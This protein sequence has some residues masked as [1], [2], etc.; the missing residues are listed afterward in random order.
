MLVFISGISTS[1]KT[2]IGKHFVECRKERGENW[3]FKDLDDFYFKEKPKIT[4]SNGQTISNWDCY[5][6]ID[7]DAAKKWLEET[8]FSDAGQN[9]CF[10]GFA[11]STARLGFQ[12]VLHFH[13]S[14][15][16]MQMDTLEGACTFNEKVVAHMVACN[17]QFS[18]GFKGKKAENDALMVREVLM[19]FYKENLKE[20]ASSAIYT[21]VMTPDGRRSEKTNICNGISAFVDKFIPRTP[22]KKQPSKFTVVTHF[23]SNN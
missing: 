1:G 16:K 14:F 11:L 23:N 5:D 7:Y 3:I 8:L 17:R 21:Q 18:K 12:P 6:A 22:I 20:I 4:L 19:P 10:V 15:C 13:L 2:T 9:V